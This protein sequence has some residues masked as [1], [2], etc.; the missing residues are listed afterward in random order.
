MAVAAL[1]GITGCSS[2]QPVRQ[3]AEFI[4]TAA[5]NVV[6]VTHRNRA[7]IVIERPRVSGDTVYGNWQGQTRAVAVPLSQVQS[8]LA[9]R[10]D[11]GRTALLVAGVTILAG[12]GVYAVV[13]SANGQN[14]WYCDYNSAV[15][16]CGRP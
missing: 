16:V 12:A 4:A 10:R 7:L 5:P 11:G 3:P 9:R 14:D 15:P 6:Y 8:M 1:A 13:Q 2:L